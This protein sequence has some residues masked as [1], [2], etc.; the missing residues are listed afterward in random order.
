MHLISYRLL[1]YR[2]L[3]LLL[4]A[5]LSGAGPRPAAA[6]PLTPLP[7]QKAIVLRQ[8][9]GS[10]VVGV[11]VQLVDPNSAPRQAVTDSGGGV[12]FRDLT[13]F[14]TV[15]FSG[16]VQGHP[17]QPP[18]DQGLPPYGTN[19]SGGG[20]LVQVEEQ[21]EGAAATPVVVAGL[22]QPEVQVSRFVLLLTPS[23][24]AITWD[25]AGA[26]GAPL[27]YTALTIG[28]D[29]ALTPAGAPVAPARVAPAAPAP[30]PTPDTLWLPVGGGLILSGLFYL[31]YLRRQE[32]RART[33]A[34]GR[35]A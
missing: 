33:A 28:V 18:A 26:T 31:G 27:P 12:V 16:T 10:P 13:G 11:T 8:L 21:D 25:L 7:P 9:D 2:L 30:V 29:S 35:D 1:P 5:L 32:R 22:V 4:A 6:A 34:A 23:G 15:L 20:F 24:W 14:W 19:T 3:G 17:I